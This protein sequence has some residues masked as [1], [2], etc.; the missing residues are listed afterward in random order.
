M[1]INTGTPG[2][3]IDG[4]AYTY[5]VGDPQRPE[6]PNYP[7]PHSSG[8]IN[9]DK[10]EPPTKDLS[11]TTKKTL[12]S[13]LGRQTQVNYYKIGAAE[14]T[15]YVTRG[16]SVTGRNNETPRIPDPSETTLN[17]EWFTKGKKNITNTTVDSPTLRNWKTGKEFIP[18]DPSVVSLQ[19]GKTTGAGQDSITG[20]ELLS[21]IDA[22]DAGNPEALPQPNLGKIDKYTS[23]VLHNNRFTN[24]NRYVARSMDA[25][26]STDESVAAQTSYIDDI[27]RDGKYNPTFYHPN[28]GELTA[29]Q[30]AQV[31]RTL[32]IRAS[33]E[34]N[35]S[36]DGNNPSSTNS[37][38]NSI[39]PSPNQLAVD[40]VKF[41]LLEA[42]DV[43]SSLQEVDEVPGD[44]FTKIAD[45]SWGALNNV[46]D[47]FSGMSTLG[48]SA[49][50]IGLSLAVGVAVGVI[51]Q[52]GWIQPTNDVAN[53][54]RN[55]I[56][57][58]GNSRILEAEYGKAEVFSPAFFSRLL[59]LSETRFPYEK[60]TVEGV[61]VFFGADGNFGESAAGL[62]LNAVTAPGY[63]AS[64]SRS[65]IRAG[66][67]LTEKIIRRSQ[68]LATRFADSS[69]ASTAV[70]LLELI[71]IIRT[72]KVIAAVNAFAFIGDMSLLSTRE[73]GYLTEIGL[74]QPGTTVSKIDIIQNGEHRKAVHKSRLNSEI[75]GS[76]TS[77]LA[78]SNYRSPSL[79]LLP[80]NVSNMAVEYKSLGAHDTG[81]VGSK[82]NDKDGSP[83]DNQYSTTRYRLMQNGNNRIPHGAGMNLANDSEIT[84]NPQTLQQIEQRLN[85]AYVP[86]YF[87]DVRTNEVISFHA[88][89]D[90]LQDGFQ[91]DYESV[92]GMGRIEP[93]KIYKG[94]TRSIG[95]SFWVAA[96][97]PQDFDD[98]WVKINKL[99]TMVYPQY[100]EGRKVIDTGYNFVQPFSQMVG[101]SP[102]VRIR[103]GNLL[104]SN[105]SRFALARLFGATLSG[106]DFELEEEEVVKPV[107][108]DI[109][110]N[111]VELTVEQVYRGLLARKKQQIISDQIRAKAQEKLAQ[112][113]DTVID[114]E[115][116]L[117]YIVEATQAANTDN[118]IAN[119]E[120]IKAIVAAD[121]EKLTPRK[122]GRNIRETAI[123]D[124][125]RNK[126]I[127]VSRQKVIDKMNEAVSTIAPIFTTES[128]EVILA[129]ELQDAKDLFSA[130]QMAT[131]S[132]D[133]SRIVEV[134][135]L[136]TTDFTLPE[137]LDRQVRNLA[138]AETKKINEKRLAAAKK[139]QAKDQAAAD[140]DYNAA[141]AEY[142]K[143]LADLQAAA[144][145][146][147]SDKIS[148]IDDFFSS[149][150]NSIVKSFRSAGGMGLAGFIESMNFEWLDNQNITWEVIKDSAP[151]LCKVTLQ[152]SPIHD[153]A[154]GL[155]SQGYNRAPVYPVG[156]FRP[157]YEDRDKGQ[158]N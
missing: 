106:A 114:R 51:G 157:S 136:D 18:P 32:S 75:E 68:A 10:N 149:D 4:K 134:Y 135:G 46:H 150:K 41:K 133:V 63:F 131:D 137:N 91:A 93:V 48:M 132:G 61:R 102:L 95:M 85:A 22:P 21:R 66:Y 44:Q 67:A 6:D 113:N 88:F 112:Q 11:K 142:E 154:P 138:V 92:S 120:L 23:A 79:Y 37:D 12:A 56:R 104:R 139:A 54:L 130:M 70:D 76:F 2:F 17:S 45:G 101:A 42:A 115:R 126:A 72:S 87:H 52:L 74:L 118:K 151:M 143:Q 123:N 86:F 146:R 31:G 83:T 64:V 25:A 24:S 29:A 65:L 50:S 148:P 34:L 28:Y 100:T 158:E 39:L 140:A 117:Q 107:R 121:V 9:V 105:Y 122:R 16:I 78:W 15:D 40:K 3:D 144:A 98:M 58:L 77:K 119:S 82:S 19:K 1:G 147:K 110:L 97:D 30:L 35:S 36:K 145:A 90:S 69:G 89:L 60:A 84:E 57:P 99:V 125:D 155:D 53:N 47:K 26:N 124:L 129:E 156:H 116:R 81:F 141:L 33:Q 14:D 103:L 111:F 71:D 55:S 127:R 20:N 109:S 13:Y 43:L 8:D 152:F 62:A 49:L 96:L 7:Q 94:T 38:L 108:K 59:G 5:D 153:I 80:E 27:T 128:N 73:E